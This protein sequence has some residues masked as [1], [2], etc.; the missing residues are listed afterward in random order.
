MA[1]GWGSHSRNCEIIRREEPFHDN[2]SRPSHGR[3][4]PMRTTIRLATERDAEAV[5]AIYAPFCSD[6]PVSFETTAPTVEEMRGR[7]A[8][9]LEILP[10]LVADRNGQVVGYAYASR[11]RERPAYVWSV[12][13]SVYV[14]SDC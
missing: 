4:N 1:A 5:L 14:Q 6:T 8:K 9:T 7:I 3:D 13:A 11:H 2:T 12:D 10:W